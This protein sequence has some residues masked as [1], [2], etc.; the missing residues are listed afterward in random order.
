M[1][2][3]NALWGT[4]QHP[5]VCR[6]R[7]GIAVQRSDVDRDR[8]RRLGPVDDQDRAGG[9]R[10]RRQPGQRHHEA[11]CGQDVGD[12]DDCTHSHHVSTLH[13]TGAC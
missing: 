2:G 4:H 13:S 1:W 11:R 12:E 7:V 9:V 6:D 5:L 10:Q 3:E 8:P